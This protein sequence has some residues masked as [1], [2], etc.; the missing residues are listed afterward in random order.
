[1]TAY[2]STRGRA[3]ETGFAGALMGGLASDGGLYVPTTWPRL[4][5]V[6]ALR[7]APFGDVVAAVLRALGADEDQQAAG[8][9]A[10]EAFAHPAVA[11]L[12]QLGPEDWL[13][14]L[15][16]GPTLAFKDVAMQALGRLFAGELA[17]TGETMSVVCA[18][19]GDTGGAA[20]AA[21]AGLP[22]VTLT[23]LFP[24]GRISE[25]Q[26]RFMTTT[27]AAN[28]ACLAVDGTFDD[29]QRIVKA[30]FADEGFRDAV[31][32]AAVNSINWAR[33][34]VQAA[35]YVTAALSLRGRASFAVP[36]GNFGDAFAGI[37]AKRLLAGDP[38][39]AIGQVVA[40]VGENDVLDRTLRTGEA[41]PRPVR[42]TQAPSMD[43]QVASNFERMIWEASGGDAE[44]VSDLLARQGR[45]EPYALPAP[46]RARIGEE[47]S[48][49]AVSD[50]DAFAEMRRTRAET[51]LLL[52]PH[53]AIGR[54]GARRARAAGLGGP[55]VTLATAH[56]AKFPGAVRRA[57][58]ATPDLPPRREGLMDA[59]EAARTVPAEVDAVADAIRALSRCVSP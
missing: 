50:E 25:V 9:S 10:Y 30:L 33:I 56:A 32:L 1:M 26:R 47:V 7:G 4:E 12:V 52:C 51:G 2:A 40:A 15:H 42:A 49:H 27:G 53:T 21:L 38:G 43:I 8:R 39:A 13:L 57:T 18:T 23:I 46:V 35:Y 5:G 45:G 3:P 20:A 34:A 22:N 17:R 59:P 19:S 11:P 54:V 31:H 37:L 16:H 29:C 14:E 44:L 6:D 41:A 58:G 55:I 48:S 36:T 28:V 24:H